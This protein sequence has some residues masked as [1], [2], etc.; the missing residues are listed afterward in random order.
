MKKCP[1]CGTEYPD[2][3]IVCA[4]DQTPFDAAISAKESVEQYKIP[5]SLSIV[6]YIFFAQGIIC[7]L[8]F[9][10]GAI[11]MRYSNS[12]RE[13]LWFFFEGVCGIILLLLSR[14]LKRCSNG[15]RIC[16]LVLIWWEII[17]QVFGVCWSLLDYIKSYGH[18]QKIKD[19]FTHEI[20]IGFW[21]IFSLGFIIQIWQYRVL[22]RENI[23][24]LFY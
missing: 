8:G 16:A 22:T 13:I 14:G 9:V 6:S 10:G 11:S 7:L 3:A 1:Y 23:R 21:I 2:D 4:N 17:S 24:E 12:G 15:W 19:A 5:K 18:Q 20:V